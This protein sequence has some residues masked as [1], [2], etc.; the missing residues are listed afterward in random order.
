MQSVNKCQDGKMLAR[1]WHLL[2][3]QISGSNSALE[4]PWISEECLLS[5]FAGVG[6]GD[7][8]SLH[9]KRIIF[10]KKLP[11][12]KVKQKIEAYI[13]TYRY[14]YMPQSP[15]WKIINW[16]M[17]ILLMKC[18]TPSAGWCWRRPG[19][20]EMRSFTCCGKCCWQWHWR[21][22]GHPQRTAP[23]IWTC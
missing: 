2:K 10:F 3:S 11:L 18:E 20:R 9:W 19:R 23:R 16:L 17:K 5:E 12:I 6:F 13:G 8:W 15:T 22:G 7:K 1:S 4:N 21:P 14:R